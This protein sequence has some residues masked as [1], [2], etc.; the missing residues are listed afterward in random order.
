MSQRNRMMQEIEKIE[1]PKELHQRSV[2]GVKQAK[3]EL[4]RTTGTMRVVKI[5]GITAAGLVL[6]VALGAAVSP[7][8]AE[9]VKSWFS[10]NK[11]DAGLK[12]AADEG[13]A[14]P[15]NKQVT[16]QGITLK[17]KEAIHD[18][19][20]VS[21]LYGVEQDG[22]PMDSDR[23]FDT[24]I[25]NGPDDDPYVNRYEVVDSEGR[26]LPLHLQQQR[27]GSD[28][29]LTLSLEDLMSSQ[30]LKSLSDLPDQITIRF[31]INQ[32]GKTSGQW[33]LDVPIDLTKAKASTE[34]VPIHKRFVSPMGFSMDFIE[35]R[36]GPSK[37]EL[38]VRVDETQGWRS[39]KKSE[40]MFR[41]EIKDGEDNVIAVFNGLN[42]KDLALGNT[43][44]IESF[45]SGQGK[46]GHITYGHPFLT[47]KDKKDLT[48]TMTDIYWME[49]AAK[50]DA[51]VLEPEK[52]VNKLLTKEVNGKSIIFKART[53]TEGA[54][55][56]MRDGSNVFVG[57]GWILETDQQ[58]GSDTIDLQW[59]I[60]DG[61]GDEVNV[62]SASELEQ[63]AAGNYHNRTLFFFTEQTMPDHITMYLESMT[64][65]APVQWSIPLVPSTEPLPPLNEDPV[66]EMTVEE[67]KPDMV[68]RAEQAMRELAPD[69]SAALYGVTDY[70]DRWFLYTKDNSGSIVIVLKETEE[71]IIVQRIIPYHELD[72]KLRQTVQDTLRQMNPEQPI[73]FK[74]A[75]RDKS[76]ENNRW[77][78]Q[79]KQA[80]IA[81]DAMTG[82]VEEASISYSPAHFDA[83]AKAAAEHAYHALSQG[84]SLRITHMMQR[85]TP[86]RHV[87]E[88]YRDM[89]LFAQ[90][91]VQSNQVWL[92][93]QNYKDDSHGDQAASKAPRYTKEQAIAK[94]NS[95]VKQ[96]FGVDL[97][98]CE[99]SVKHNEYTFT[100]EDQT[101]I[102]G[103]VNAQGE[104]WKLEW[105]PKDGIQE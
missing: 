12:K 76:K 80:E 3:R 1:I 5:A 50:E 40:P 14:V 26:V 54:P 86:K 96:V 45:W 22:K 98:D 38:M 85:M 105:V 35:L 27:A 52:L 66:Y 37:S 59:R 75:I 21:I 90:V 44:V 74:E 47:F 36:H 7:T 78:F 20:R 6:V 61:Q 39:G 2:L 83:K 77:L 28:R 19:L 63:D 15:I 81:I 100:L 9:Y 53:K 104:F 64:K 89:S 8:F 88:F 97:K 55:E 46:P 51:V 32:I 92:V 71:P 65:V 49:R 79:N 72:S 31:D 29:I 67:L 11:T 17:V 42:R 91:D 41:Y 70:G 33:H 58:L 56:Q 10:L 4:K 34:M 95:T 82:K 30:G 99:V 25:P 13:F 43:N 57:K 87:W 101:A 69:K 16:D 62:Q 23:L 84:K 102:R 24:F 94:V 48:L 73:V 60:K 68:K 103:T 93:Q 18:V